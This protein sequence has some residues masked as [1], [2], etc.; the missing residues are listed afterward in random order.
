M[1]FS[2]LVATLDSRTR[3]LSW[4]SPPR[5][6]SIIL[7]LSSH[8]LLRALICFSLL[9]CIL[10]SAAFTASSIIDL[11]LSSPSPGLATS[12]SPGDAC[13]PCSTVTSPA[14]S[15]SPCDI[16]DAPLLD[17]TLRS[18]SSTP[19]MLLSSCCLSSPSCSSAKVWVVFT[20]LAS[21]TSFFSFSLMRLSWR[22]RA[23]SRS[24]FFL[25][26]SSL[27]SASRSFA[28]RSSSLS[29]SLA[30]WACSASS[31]FF[32]SN[33]VLKTSVSR[34]RMYSSSSEALGPPPTELPL[35]V[36]GETHPPFPLF[37]MLE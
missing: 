28:S 22:S 3:S 18:L 20:R 19:S 37:I 29:R 15:P 27:S 11:A 4:Y 13:T 36:V 34:K 32:L 23:R 5:R 14:P 9:L 6:S 30:L 31:F 26:S 16:D 8:L 25:S 17:S 12:G 1:I 24:A 33:S 35:V 7:S 10:S 2:S 21:V